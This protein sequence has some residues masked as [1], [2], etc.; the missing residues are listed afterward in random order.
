MAIK[1]ERQDLQEGDFCVGEVKKKKN[2]K[3]LNPID[4]GSKIPDKS[5]FKDQM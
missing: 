1:N 2:G 3:T 5:T 4:N